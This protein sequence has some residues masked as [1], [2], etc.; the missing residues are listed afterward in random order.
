[1]FVSNNTNISCHNPRPCH[2][3]ML[4]SSFQYSRLFKTLYQ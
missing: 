4:K 1:M 2:C 3:E